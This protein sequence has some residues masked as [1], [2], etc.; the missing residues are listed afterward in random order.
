MAEILLIG[1]CPEADNVRFL[2]ISMNNEYFDIFKKNKYN[3]AIGYLGEI[4]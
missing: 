2:P 4:I 3:L 1:R